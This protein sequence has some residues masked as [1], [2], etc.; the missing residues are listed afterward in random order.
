[1]SSANHGKVVGAGLAERLPSDSLA[2]VSVLDRFDFG[3]DV[4]SLRRPLCCDAEEAEA[5]EVEA[6]ALSVFLSAFQLLPAPPAWEV[7]ARF[8]SMV[9]ETVK[10]L[11]RQG[12]D[13]PCDWT[14]W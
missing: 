6:S 10:M 8:M 5:E 1:M 2:M 13:G 4:E 12:A 11:L 14:I 9:D 7:D 3:C